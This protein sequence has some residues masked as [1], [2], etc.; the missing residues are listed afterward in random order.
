MKKKLTVNSL[1]LSSIKTRKKQ[2]ALMIVGIIFAMI[3]SSAI[4]FFGSSLSSSMKEMSKNSVGDCDSIISNVDQDFIQMLYDDGFLSDYGFAHIIGYAESEDCEENQGA[5]IAYLDDRAMRLSY[6]SFLEGRYPEKEG[7]IALEKATLARFRMTDAKI[8][9][10]ITLNFYN[11]N[12]SELAAKPVQKTYTIVGIAKNK[13]T[14]ILSHY[15]EAQQYFKMAPSAFVYQGANTDIGGK[16]SLSCYIRNNENFRYKDSKNWYDAR[17]EYLQDKGFENGFYS[18]GMEELT[19]YADRYQFLEGGTY[20]TI[21]LAVVLVVVLLFASAIGIINAFNTNLKD[22]KKQIGLLRTVGATRQQIIHIYGREAFII[23]LICTPVSV[24]ISYFLVKLVVKLLGEEFIFVPNILVLLLSGVVSIIFVMLAACIPLLSASRISPMQSIRNI[25]LTRKMKYKKIKSKKSFNTPSL[26][27]KRSLVFHRGKRIIVSFFL[28]GTIILSCYGFSYLNYSADS[29]Y[30]PE[31]DY[32]LSDNASV[33]YSSLYNIKDMGGGFNENQK[34]DILLSPYVEKVMGSKK[35]KALI[36]TDAFTE[37]EKIVSY[38]F[39]WDV[40]TGDFWDEEGHALEITKDNFDE[41]LT[42]E[43]SE[44]YLE[45]KNHFSINKDFYSIDLTSIDASNLELLNSSVIDGKIDINKINSGEE[46]IL[47]APQKVGLKFDLD[48]RH[49]ASQELDR[50]D[51]F[52]S[53]KNEYVKTAECEYKAG[54]YIDMSVITGKMLSDEEGDY[55]IEYTDKKD[56]KVKIGAII[57]DVPVNVART[58]DLYNEFTLI[59]SIGGF[60]SF[61]PESRYERFN[62]YLKTECNDEINDEMETLLKNVAAATT[63]NVNVY[64]QYGMQKDEEQGKTT[65]F[66]AMLSIIIL[67]LSISASIIN[68]S[69]SAQIREGKREIGTLRAVGASRREIVMSYIKQLISIFG[70]GYGIGFAGFGITY[71]IF[72]FISYMNAKEFGYDFTG[73]ELKVTLWQTVLACV[74]LFAVCSINLMIK[75]GKE[76]KNSIIDNIREL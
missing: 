12:G 3:F 43:F 56:H 74:I 53:K 57:S 17:Y 65:L 9:D 51:D 41:M 1:A 36:M 15:G 61:Y 52:D 8:G 39:C 55:G 6:I 37:Y 32:E 21:F 31:Y 2:Y 66:V 23:S 45:L 22:R 14:N 75:T 29:L 16:E 26:L 54:D 46:V 11:K 5:A 40:F 19:V 33:F 64:S 49:G 73:L 38:Y 24:V 50:D 69:F 30:Q 48:D 47:I 20:N 67:F 25:E 71:G 62:I 70:W 27:A 4:L 60:E 10:T 72:N 28:I 58:M 59:T 76:M 42:S 7:E 18:N 63:P 34:R 13:L 68:N 35:C 44:D